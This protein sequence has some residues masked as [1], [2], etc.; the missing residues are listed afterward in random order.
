MT[1]LGVC[2][3]FFFNTNEHRLGLDV[4]S[5][6]LKRN[7][8]SGNNRF[9]TLGLQMVLPTTHFC[10]ETISHEKKRLPLSF[11]FF[12]EK[13]TNVDL[14]FFLEKASVAIKTAM[15]ML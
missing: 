5:K 8:I 2:S 6:S 7:G 15:A 10:H 1:L 14:K 9:T 4:L 11:L 3:W 12:L 13:L